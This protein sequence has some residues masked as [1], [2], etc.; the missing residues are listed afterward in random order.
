MFKWHI[1]DFLFEPLTKGHPFE[2]ECYSV[3]RSHFGS[4]TLQTVV[5]FCMPSDVFALA[6]LTY[7]LLRDLV[8]RSAVPAPVECRCVFEGIQELTERIH[9]APPSECLL[10]KSLVETS[11]S[12]PVTCPPCQQS[13]CADFDLSNPWLPWILVVCALWFVIGVLCGRGCRRH[14]RP[15][16]TEQD[17]SIVYL[18]PAVCTEQDRST[19]YLNP[20]APPLAVESSGAKPPSR[21]ELN[22][23]RHSLGL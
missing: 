17:R 3:F 14:P 8:P 5:V 19:V 16:C 10:L 22:E 11:L 7:T 9:P 20:T 23:W 2:P 13:E 21:K 6:H 1:S 12:T 15:V 18:N 4:K